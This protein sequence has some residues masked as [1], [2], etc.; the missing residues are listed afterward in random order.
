[1][2]KSI[3]VSVTTANLRSIELRASALR[4]GIGVCTKTL[5]FPNVDVSLKLIEWIELH[6]EQGYKRVGKRLTSYFSCFTPFQAHL[7]ESFSASLL[8]KNM[9]NLSPVQ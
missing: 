3:P 8:I 4:S 6:R 5:L 1:M 9:W 7:T 2:R